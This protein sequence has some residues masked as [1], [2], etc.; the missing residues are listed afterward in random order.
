MGVRVVAYNIRMGFGLDGRLDLD[1]LAR[2]VTGS[3]PDVVVLSEVD[4]GWLLNGATTPSRCW[5]GSCA[6]RTSS[7]RQPL[8]CGATRRSRSP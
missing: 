8:R 4:R 7:R 6:C 2:A 1:G 5:P 3:R